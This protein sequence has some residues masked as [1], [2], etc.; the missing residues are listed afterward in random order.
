MPFS[1][2]E[3][4]RFLKENKIEDVTGIHAITNSASQRQY[5]RVERESGSLIL[6]LSSHLD[7]NKTFLYFTNCM[8]EIQIRVP[9]VLAVSDDFTMYLQEDL[10]DT[11]LL[12]C[13]QSQEENVPN[14]IAVTLKDVARMQTDLPKVLD[15][16]KSFEFR[17]MDEKLILN[18]LF[19]FKNYFLEYLEI[20]FPKQKLIEDFYSIAQK[21]DDLPHEFFMYRDFQSRNILIHH[22]QTYYIDYQ[23]GMQGIAAYD[24]VSFSWQ[25]KANFSPEQK[26]EIK[27]L[28]FE[29]MQKLSKITTQDLEDS[30]ELSV[31]IR[32]FQ[33]LGAYGFRGL[34]QQ[35]SHFKESINNTLQNIQLIQKEGLLKDYPILDQLS[36]YY[37]HPEKI[38]L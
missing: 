34:V 3:I 27:N 14:Y 9:K 31:V 12:S 24:C 15:F 10:G 22:N 5:F 7:E 1:E 17:T 16:D 33:L 28:Y 29:E 38:Q 19:Y 6:T 36:Q 21:V 37:L 32:L 20:P 35:K 25:A 2:Q 4:Q 8:H 23:G 30:Y 26:L 18:D 13:I 11:N